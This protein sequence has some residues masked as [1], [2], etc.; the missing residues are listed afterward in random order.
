[1]AMAKFMNE[2]LMLIYVNY[3]PQLDQTPPVLTKNSPIHSKYCY[4]HSVLLNPLAI[5]QEKQT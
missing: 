1:M 5:S 3:P 4:N 2:I